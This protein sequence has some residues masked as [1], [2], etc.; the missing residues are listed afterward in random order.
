MTTGK[1]G[2]GRQIYDKSYYMLTLRTKR[3][4]LTTEIQKFRTEI[5]QIQTDN[6]QYS[7]YEKR[8]DELIKSVRNLE[9]DLADYNL[10]LDKNRTDT[11]PEEVQHMFFLL[12][13]QN[14]QQ[15]HDLDAIFLEKKHHE[16]EI[17]KIEEEIGMIRKVA[18]DRLNEL[19]P[20]A[21]EE[22][23][24]L[25]EEN[26][27][28]HQEMGTVRMELDRVNTRLA[29]AEG[30][31]R[32]DVLR[33]RSQQQRESLQELYEK[34]Q[35]LKD[36]AD[37]LK[38]SIPEQRELLL[39]KVKKENLDIVAAEKSFDELRH[40]IQRYKKQSQ[41]METDI[42]ERKGEST[43][44]QK[45]EM[46]FSKDQEMSQFI[47][48]FDQAKREEEEAMHDKQRNIVKLLTE[49]SKVISREKNLP[50][51]NAVREMEEELEFKGKQLANSEITVVRLR[52]ELDR[53][54]GELDKINSLDNKISTE[55]QQLDVKMNQF[56]A[57]IANK[58]NHV[59]ELKA[60]GARFQ[61]ELETRKERLGERVKT[62]KQQVTARKLQYDALKQQLADNEVHR[63]LETQE[64]KLRQ[65]QKSVLYLSSFVAGKTA[66][67]D[68][69]QTQQAVLDIVEQ[70]NQH[71]QKQ[72]HTNFAG[73]L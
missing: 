48:G 24:N 71:L 54:S 63:A 23:E 19:H 60:E 28:L 9:G 51:Q 62:M 21:R 41:E 33:M 39:A 36:E 61:R 13:Q 2:P 53:R 42:N 20:D 69:A 55:L 49:M 17:R 11:R 44:Q 38:L 66:E 73:A 26:G 35:K 65:I 1:F 29:T 14:D 7:R 8:Y 34:Q 15:R 57:D 6:N 56:Q 18:E 52:S 68:Y 25:Q 64:G 4:D 59:D 27:R 46:L 43:D 58:Y 40:E 67:S 37:T 10:A 31:L 30:R 45:Y 3:D 32:S 70:V 72:M 47:E 5:D 16:E 50:A 12:K 22:Y